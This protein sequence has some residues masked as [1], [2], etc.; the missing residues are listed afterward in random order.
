MSTIYELLSSEHARTYN[1]NAVNQMLQNLE[2]GTFY[3]GGQIKM[4]KTDLISL[5]TV[6]KSRE[7]TKRR[8]I[9]YGGPCNSWEMHSIRRSEIELKVVEDLVLAHIG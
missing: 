9:E 4:Q 5:E 1:P 8:L 3:L 7:I 6:E 2:K